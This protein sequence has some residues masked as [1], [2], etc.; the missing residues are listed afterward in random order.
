[1]A[2]HIERVAGVAGGRPRVGTLG[3]ALPAVHRQLHPVALFA[4]GD[5]VPA[6]V[7][8][9]VALGRVLRRDPAGPVVHV[10]EELRGGEGREGVGGREEP[11]N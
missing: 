7:A 2:S 8:E 11:R 3:S 5:A 6:T 4:G 10:E 1:M 9:A